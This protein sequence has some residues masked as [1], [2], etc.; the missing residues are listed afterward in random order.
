MVIYSFQT[1]QHGFPH[2]PTALAYD[3]KDKLMAIGTHS[4]TIKV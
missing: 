3:S 2:K 1:V 4:G